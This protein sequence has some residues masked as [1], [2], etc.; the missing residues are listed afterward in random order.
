MVKIF[1]ADDEK[2]IRDL[3]ASFLEKE[4][5]QVSA[6]ETGDQLLL[7]FLEETPDLVV[8]DIT[9]PGTSGLEIARRIKEKSEVPVLLLTARDSDDDY[10]KGFSYGVDDY[11]I[12]PFSPVKLMVKIKVLLGKKQPLPAKV[13]SLAYQ[14]LSLNLSSREICYQGKVI[15]LTKNEFLVLK[16]LLTAPHKS[17]SREELLQEIWGYSSDIETR[18]TDDTMKRLRKKLGDIKSPIK[19]ETVWGFGFR[20]VDGDEDV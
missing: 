18:V 6:F 5:Y 12:K 15:Q 14:D 1:L 2:N 17:I 20:I 3:L 11:F 13:D 16:A 9:M 7:Q 4:G 10:E 19:I 8:L